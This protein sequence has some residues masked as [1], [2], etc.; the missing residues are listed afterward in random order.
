MA[1]IIDGL[2]TRDK[3]LVSIKEEIEANGYTPKLSVVLAGNDKASEVYV[4]NKMRTCKKV[5]ISSETITLPEDVSEEVVLDVINKLNNDSTV[6]GILIQLPLPK[7]INEMRVIESVSHIKDVDCFHPLNVGKLYLGDEGFKPCTPYGIITLLKEYNVELR[8]KNLCILG[9]SNIVGKP[10]MHLALQEDATVTVCHSKTENLKNITK[11]ADILIVAIGKG[12]FVT[13][14]FVKDNAIVID[15]GIHRG[16][17]GKLFG[18][19]NFLEVE[20]IASLITPVPGGVGPMTIGTL[21]Y[22]CLS[23]YKNQNSINEVS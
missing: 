23:A 18:D 6:N 7:H 5:G 13:K 17:D 16:D 10:M 22:N 2:V 3:F 15:V 20:K 12:N 11:Q 21:M 14:E 9:R 19:V 8:G 4:K 1:K